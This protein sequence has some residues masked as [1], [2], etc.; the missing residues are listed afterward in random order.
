MVPGSERHVPVLLQDAIRYLNVRAGG[1]YVDATLGFAGHAAAIARELGGQGQLIGFDRDPEALELARERLQAL[2]EELGD[3]MPQWVLYGEP[4]S[5][6][7]RVHCGG[8]R[9]WIAGRLWGQLHAAGHGAQ[10]I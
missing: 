2:G 9:G 6:M 5:A 8:Q 4:F 3:Q 1:T 10:R 7:S